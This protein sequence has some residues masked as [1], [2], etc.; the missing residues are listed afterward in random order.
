MKF[1]KKL[2]FLCKSMVAQ[3]YYKQ[4][5]N[6]SLFIFCKMSK[7]ALRRLQGCE[8]RNYHDTLL[9]MFPRSRTNEILCKPTGKK[10]SS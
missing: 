7:H 10:T 1:K 3:K 8:P 9:G 4:K 5:T 6:D 2:F